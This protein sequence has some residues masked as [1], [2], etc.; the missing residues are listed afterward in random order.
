MTY[1]LVKYFDRSMGGIKEH[2]TFCIDGSYEEAEKYIVEIVAKRWGCPIYGTYL[3]AENEAS[4]NVI[5]VLRDELLEV[6]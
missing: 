6:I 2:V 1:L 3:R 4:D 5:K